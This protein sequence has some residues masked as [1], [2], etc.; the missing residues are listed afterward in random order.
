MPYSSDAQRRWAHTESA[1]KAGFPTE[2]FDKASK[3]KKLPEK[4]MDEGGPVFTQ[5]QAPE[6]QDDQFTQG[7]QQGFKGGI[8]NDLDSMKQ[9][10]ADF[11]EKIHGNYVNGMGDNGNLKG[12][13]MVIKGET[14]PNMA[15]GGLTFPHKEK[16]GPGIDTTPE[17]KYADGGYATGDEDLPELSTALSAP[18]SSS[19]TAIDPGD[20]A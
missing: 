14:E 18:D 5:G 7:V 3:G 6:L 2:E 12:L 1:K 4:K 10:V 9:A 8:N 20:A 11:V 15:G 13:E 19:G 16:S 17:H